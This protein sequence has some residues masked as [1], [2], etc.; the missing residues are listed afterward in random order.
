[1]MA[2]RVTTAA[3][4]ALKTL[5]Q[6][7]CTFGAGIENSLVNSGIIGMGLPGLRE[8]ESNR[9]RYVMAEIEQVR[10]GGRGP[11][12]RR[13]GCDEGSRSIEGLPIAR[14]G[15]CSFADNRLQGPREPNDDVLAYDG[16][17]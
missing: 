8:S 7:G 1:M 14:A 9:L 6:V 13:R 15:S 17:V 11:G 16:R 12:C 3:V 4:V 5:G 10:R 2:E